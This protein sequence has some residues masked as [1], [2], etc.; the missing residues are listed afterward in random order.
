[1]LILNIIYLIISAPITNFYMDY[2]TNKLIAYNKLSISGA[3]LLDLSVFLIDSS[4]KAITLP[5]ERVASGT[6]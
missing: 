6:L 2:S 3:T 4:N 1:M 5:Q